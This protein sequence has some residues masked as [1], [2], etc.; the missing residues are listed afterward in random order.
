MGIGAVAP[1]GTRKMLIF[2][3]LVY[4][5]VP[6]PELLDPHYLGLVMASPLFRRQVESAMRS[7]SGQFKI[8]KDDLRSFV[9]PAPTLAEQ[10]RIVD[11]L[12]A[13]TDKRRAVMESLAKLKVLR[14]GWIESLN[15]GDR[16]RL[17]DIIVS[18][19]QNGI[20]KPASS[21]GLT[22]TR[23]VRIDSFNGGPSELGQQLLRVDV[24]PSEIK[25][26]GLS[27]GDLIVNRVNTVELVG[28]S[29]VVSRLDEVTI[30]ESNVMRCRLS[31]DVAIPGFVEA[32][33]SSGVVKRYFLQRA[34]SAVSQASINREDVLSC[35][36][37]IIPIGGQRDFLVTLRKIDARIESEVLERRKLEQLGVGL[38]GDLLSEG[39]RM[40]Q[41]G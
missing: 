41:V 7:T 12:E 11:V 40:G 14:S 33:M 9:I 28:K 39:L 24:S 2:P 25:R 26:Y 5:L 15:E 18:G 3:D 34:K 4:R 6:D 31:P 16:Y 22:G 17:D 36:F 37:P 35:P 23:I 32:W 38:A 8:S 19:P 21:Y 29:T 13:L 1:P 10:R 20:Y 27:V 30:F